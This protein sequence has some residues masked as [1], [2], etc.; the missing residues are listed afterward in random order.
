VL[1]DLWRFWGD[2]LVI[3]TL[4]TMVRVLPNGLFSL[5]GLE[6]YVRHVL[7]TN[8]RSN[9]FRRLRR[10][11]FIP[12]TVLDSGAIHTFG[13]QINETTPISMAVAASAAIPLVYTPVRIAGVD[14]VDGGV[15]K[16][17]HAGLAVDLGTPLVIVVNPVRPVVLD[18]TGVNRISDGGPFAVAGQALRVVLQRR[19]HEGLRRHAIQRT[20]TDILLL[21]P[22]ERDLDLFDYPLM[23]YT[24]RQEVIRRGY[25]TTIKVLLG[26]YERYAAVFAR[27]GIHLGPRD[28]IERRAQRWGRANRQAA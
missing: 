5:N 27:H 16:T 28:A 11:L 9:D 3:D 18:P 22:Y 17:A 21:E 2:A 12:A 25:R 26:D 13:A 15:T 14:Y 6:Q 7:S 10:R 19:L 20:D 1:F 4:A 24:L 23:T 8:G